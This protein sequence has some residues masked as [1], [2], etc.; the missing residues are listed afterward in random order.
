MLR[1][2]KAIDRMK[3][4]GDQKIGADIVRRALEAPIRQ[5][6]EN[7]GQDGAIVAQRVEQDSSPT[8]GY[9]ALTHEY[10][11]MVKEGVIVPMKVERI[12][13]QNAASIA[14]L[15]LTT[16]ALVSEIPEKKKKSAGGPPMDEDMY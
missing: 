4:K 8:F 5:I 7:A 13:L 15:L 16:D 6:S 2:R 12:A 3:L 9:N 14:G 1:S 11:D 10:G